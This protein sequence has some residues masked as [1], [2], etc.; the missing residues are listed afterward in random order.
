MYLDNYSCFLLPTLCLESQ[1]ELSIAG[2]VCIV[3][4]SSDDGMIDV[5]NKELESNSLLWRQAQFCRRRPHVKFLSK[6]QIFTTIRPCTNVPEMH[7]IN[8]SQVNILAAAE[9]PIA[10]H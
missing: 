7:S 1:I 5:V 9:N 6:F 4:S 10:S 8:Q 2:K 3:Q